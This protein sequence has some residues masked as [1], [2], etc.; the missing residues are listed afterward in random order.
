MGNCIFYQTSS[1]EGEETMRTQQKYASFSQISIFLFRLA[2][3]ELIT[4]YATDNLSLAYL[5][6]DTEI[7]KISF[8]NISIWI[9][10]IYSWIHTNTM[11]YYPHTIYQIRMTNLYISFGF[12]RSRSKSTSSYTTY[13]SS[14]P[15]Y[16]STSYVDC[17]INWNQ[18]PSD[19]NWESLCLLTSKSP[20]HHPHHKSGG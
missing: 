17:E 8:P 9:C 6:P 4:A 3:T 11:Q 5:F 16:V 18:L 7:G 1:I 2:G 20:H 14:V 12:M 13:P 19:I 15:T 10:R